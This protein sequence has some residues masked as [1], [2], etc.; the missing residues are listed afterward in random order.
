MDPRSLSLI[1]K[2]ISLAAKN[3]HKIKAD[4]NYIFKTQLSVS[5]AKSE[6]KAGLSR[7]IIIHMIIHIAGFKI[8]SFDLFE[9]LFNCLFCI[10]SLLFLVYFSFS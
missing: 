4:V 9:Y 3:M 5:M 2:L 8:S 6:A 10:L 7:Y 1:N